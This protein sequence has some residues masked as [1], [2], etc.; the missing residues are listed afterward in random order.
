MHLVQHVKFKKATLRNSEL[1]VTISTRDCEIRLGVSKIEK[2][3]P[4]VL[5]CYI[6]ADY[7]GDLDQ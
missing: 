7:A 1:G 3:K 5:Q 6:D 4:R 2:G